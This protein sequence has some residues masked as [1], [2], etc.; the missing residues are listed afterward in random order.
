F[1]LDDWA[2][3]EDFAREALCDCFKVKSLKG[4]GVDELASGIT[5]AGAI[6]QYLK[7]T[8]HTQLDHLA[9]LSRL[10]E[11][12]YLW[13]DKF[14]IRNLEL[15]HPNAEGGKCLLDII[16]ATLTPMGGRTLRRWILLP[17]KEEKDINKRLDAVGYFGKNTVLRTEIQDQLK[18]INDLERLTGKIATG[19]INPREM[20]QLLNSL[21]KIQGIRERMAMD[22]QLN[23]ALKTLLEQL[24]PCSELQKLLS[25]SLEPDAPWQLQK[26]GVIKSGLS[27]E[28]DEL[29]ELANNSKDKLLAMQNREIEST[30]ISSLKIA[31]NNVFGYYIEVRNTHKDKVPGNWVRKQTLV[32]AE[33][34]I[35]EELK[36]FEQ[37]ILGA[38][39]R[40]ASL[41]FEL[42]QN[43][44][45]DL[46]T[47]VNSIQLNA[48]IIGQ[49]DV[50]VGFAEVAQ[51][52]NYSKPE[53]NSTYEI[54][55]KAG[56]HPVIEQSLEAT[57][58]YIPNDVYLDRDEQQIMM[59]TGPNM[60]GKSAVLRQTALICLMAQMGSFVPAKAAKI[61]LLDKVFS[62][63]GASD[64]ITSGESTFMVE[65]NETAS[66]LNNMSDR[67]LILLDE[68]GRGTSTYDGISIA[69]S[70]AEYLHQN[71]KYKAKTLFAT[72]Y[73]ELN[74]MEKK[75]E[76]I[77]NYH[78]SV[79]E[80]DKKI[81]FLR[82][83]VKGGSEHSFGIHV[84]KLAGMPQTVTH[85]AEQVLKSL[86]QN[87]NK[88]GASK[89]A[90]ID[91]VSQMQ[92][93]IFKLDDPVLEQIRDELQNLDINSLTP[94]EAL[95]KLNEIQKW[96]GVKQK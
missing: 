82:K 17:L 21:E 87:H 38:E 84:A 3:N 61:G 19:R 66:I 48:K 14:T 49:L 34:Y 4:F 78:V 52:N 58:S 62:R 50:L 70:I 39:E 77:C 86:E 95:M 37:K 16:D 15:I 83:L 91:A 44:I 43:L 94:V 28:L 88:T 20:L 74:Q 12:S 7:E 81:L 80:V 25:D 51:I 75:F 57:E 36:V 11:S 32:N 31:F 33:R 92:L 59:I 40:I 2:F 67:S 71:P 41:E 53:V 89:T 27:P 68:I 65:M 18:Q 56:R 55:I 24:N 96:V 64:N 23:S 29:R 6:L 35:T 76:R 45:S 54:D 5:A 90:E 46:R 26:G 8:H 79:K 42:F 10:D 30:G 47:Y 63:V 60:S 72:H 22:K 93:S 69:W 13:L 1:C 85:R 9:G 73:H